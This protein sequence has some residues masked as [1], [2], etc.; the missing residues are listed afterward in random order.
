[1]SVFRL[2]K[3]FLLL[4]FGLINWTVRRPSG[5][6]SIAVGAKSICL[7]FRTLGLPVGTGAHDALSFLFAFKGLVVIPLLA[8]PALKDKLLFRV[9]LRLDAFENHL[10]QINTI[11]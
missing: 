10:V 11:F 7:L 9:L 5:M 6:S 4:D 3:G 1:M 8:I 2:P